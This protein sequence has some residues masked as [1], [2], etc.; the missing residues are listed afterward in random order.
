MLEDATMYG[1][2]IGQP[3]NGEGSYGSHKVVRLKEEITVDGNGKTSRSSPVGTWTNF[4]EC[5]PFVFFSAE[6]W[7]C[8]YSILQ[9]DLVCGYGYDLIWANCAPN[10]TGVL[11]K[12]TIVHENRK[13]GSGANKNF[14]TRCGAEGIFAF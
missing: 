14:G 3:A 6:V 1:M 5:G 13:P 8:V 2:K 12:H 4:V 11:H 10:H 7:P 9:P